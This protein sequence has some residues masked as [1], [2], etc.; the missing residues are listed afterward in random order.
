[1]SSSRC[2]AALLCAFCFLLSIVPL[3]AEYDILTRYNFSRPEGERRFWLYSPTRYQLGNATEQH[4][5]PLIMFFH[6]FSDT[7]ELQGY[8][9]Q[10]SI[11]A[12]VAEVPTNPA[13]VLSCSTAEPPLSQHDTH[14]F[15]YLCLYAFH[16]RRCTSTTSR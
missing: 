7:C 8:I 9:S 14:S 11:W 5:L 6:G 12:Y 2:I 16:L 10:F 4:P 1:M 13:T 3:Q 15:V